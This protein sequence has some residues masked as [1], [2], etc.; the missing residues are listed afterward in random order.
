METVLNGGN[1][2]VPKVTWGWHSYEACSALTRGVIRGAVSNKW[3]HMTS[4]LLRA[5]VDKYMQMVLE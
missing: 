1:A 5:I 4:C 3:L 2:N